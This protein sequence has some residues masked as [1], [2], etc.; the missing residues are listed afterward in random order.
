M[1]KTLKKELKRRSAIEPHIGHMKNDGRLRRNF[2]KYEPGCRMNSILCA[3]G[4]NLR[5]LMRLI[6]IVLPC[7]NS[8]YCRYFTENSSVGLAVAHNSRLQ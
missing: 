8:A 5:F 7:S 6:R 2:L 3:I 4:H 1:T